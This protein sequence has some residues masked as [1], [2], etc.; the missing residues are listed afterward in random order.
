MFIFF[1][2]ASVTACCPDCKTRSQLIFVI[3][4]KNVM[5]PSHFRKQFQFQRGTIRKPKKT[6]K[7]EAL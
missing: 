7:K 5:H 1:M 4:T 2:R 3:L 6:D